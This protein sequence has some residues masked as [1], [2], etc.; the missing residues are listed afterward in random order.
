MRLSCVQTL[1]L[2]TATACGPETEPAVGEQ[3]DLAATY[4]EVVATYLQDVGGREDRGEA[5][6]ID[7]SARFVRGDAG[8]W[9]AV[10]SLLGEDLPDLDVPLEECTRVE[11]SAPRQARALSSPVEF[12]DVGGL[13]LRTDGEEVRIPDW[14]FPS[15]Y[16]V[17]SGVLY[18]GEGALST[19]YHPEHEYR[20]TSSGSSQIAPFEASL[21][22]PAELTDL[23][24]AGAEVGVEPVRLEGTAAP[25]IRW[26]PA[27]DAAEVVAELSW[28]QFALEQRVVCR[29]RDDGSLEIPAMIRA[30][31]ADPGVSDVRLSVHRVTRTAIAAD[32]LD[33]GE[34]LF[35]VTVTVPV[36]TP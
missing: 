2:L 13:L 23:V 14:S 29:S 18:G 30:R 4:G 24:V 25:E 28:S 5:D 36:A 26:E 20:V 6:A 12:L 7:I 16:G 11:P 15:V 9:P 32:G 35:V 1:L 31:L 34:A 3:T 21:V 8:D 22:A 10:R 27:G 19:P 17:V 33:D